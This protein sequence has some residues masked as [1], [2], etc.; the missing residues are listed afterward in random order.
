MAKIMIK[1][2]LVLALIYVL[3]CAVLFVMQRSF[4]YFP[5]PRSPSDHSP[6]M[7]LKTNEGIVL[8]TTREIAGGSALIY[9]GGNGEDV[10]YN[11]PMLSKAFPGAALYL[12]NYRGYGGSA[13]KPTE[14]SI[15]SDAENLFDIVYRDH[16]DIVL[17]GRSLGTGVAVHLA[18]ERPV[19]KL[20]LTTPYYSIQELASSQFR[21]F[22]IRWLLLDKYESWKYS[23]KVT[24]PTVIVQAGKD[25]VIPSDSTAK[26]FAT[27]QTGIAKLKV[28]SGDGHNSISEFPEYDQYI[29][30][31]F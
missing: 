27:F 13:G 15:M 28:I 23:P 16:K 26:L 11:L 12:M 6:K 22:P 1:L 25:E 2:A 18:S 7:E 10:S 21:F 9:F 17:I 20:I 29:Q 5:Q 19:K 14:A 8:V 24:A 30:G 4:L 31:S 3:I